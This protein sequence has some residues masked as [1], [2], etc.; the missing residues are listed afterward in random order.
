MNVRPIDL[1]DPSRRRL[2]R[3]KRPSLIRM[4]AL[5]LTDS[6]TAILGG[7]AG[8]ATALAMRLIVAVA[9]ASEAASLL[10]ISGAHIDGCLYNGLASLDFARRLADLG[11]TVRVPT[12]LNVSS[13]DLLHPELMTSDRD[14]QMRARQLMDS[15]TAMGAQ[16]TWTCA[17][18]QLPS[19]P[20]FGQHV[21]WGESNA[22]VFANS[23]LGARTA[24]YG[25]FIDIAAA[26][27]GRAPAAGLHLDQ[28]RR[29]GIV[30]D[31]SGF[32]EALIKRD[33][34]F[35]VLGLVVGAES[36]TDVPAIIGIGTATEDQLKI[37]GASAA[38]AG[39]VG[40]FHVVGIT[41]EAPTLDAVVGPSHHILTVTPA[42][43]AIARDSIG[44]AAGNE[45]LGSVNLGTPHY[46]T[47][48]LEHL[49][50]LLAGRQVRAP[51]YVSTGRDTLTAWGRADQLADLGVTIVTDT[52]TYVT[53]I[54]DPSK[55]VAMT[56]SGKWAYY[57]PGNLG[58][59]VAFGSVEECVESAIAG[60]IVR[61]DGQWS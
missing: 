5:A 27:T 6:D 45:R 4:T 44:R 56:D 29:A 7:E 18:Y 25:D 42:M 38:S 35:A 57:A 59:T 24:R 50:D 39:S 8:E 22:I 9:K 49:L 43:L 36:A 33:A 34:F 48:Q 28:N 61:M 47:G 54:I 23:V 40:L 60:R 10:D 12:T 20:A 3:E 55:G 1:E 52:C 26:I 37:M 13:L 41:P 16:A 58:A 21:A 11:A 53:S 46:S 51:L 15:Y 17:P 14:T 30:F 2:R 32:S 19:R 31:V